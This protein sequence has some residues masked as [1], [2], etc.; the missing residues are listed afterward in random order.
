MKYK[1]IKYLIPLSAVAFVAI[2]AC[3]GNGGN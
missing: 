3:N 2:T 1:Q